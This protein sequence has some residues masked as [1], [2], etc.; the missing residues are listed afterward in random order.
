MSNSSS[1]NLWPILGR[2]TEFPFGP[3]LIAVY[4]GYG[5][6]TSVND[7]LK[8]FIN[9]MNDIKQQ[10][11][12]YHGRQYQLNLTAVICDAPARTFVKCIKGHSGYNACERC[13]KEGV[14]TDSRMTFP[15]TGARKRTDAEFRVMLCEDHHTAVSP[16]AQ[17][18]IGCV[19]NFPLDNMH[20]VCLG[21]V[22]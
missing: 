14:Y 9:E 4:S 5:K 10:G 15:E 6:P 8:D 22:R 13:V 18:D 11:F 2:I 16:F 19:S 7:L 21:I 20:L 1:L 17:Y 12:A 3:F